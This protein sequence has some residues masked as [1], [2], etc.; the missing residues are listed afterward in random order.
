MSTVL[1]A[2]A[3][4][5]AVTP[6]LLISPAELTASLKDPASIGPNASYQR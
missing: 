6:G 2:L 4:A 1:T 5:A 3:V